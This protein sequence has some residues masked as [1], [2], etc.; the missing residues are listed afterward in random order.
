MKTN[1]NSQNRSSATG[2]TQAD[3]IKLGMDV[4]AET[5]VVVRILDKAT[6]SWFQ[7]RQLHSPNRE[8]RHQFGF[9]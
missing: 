4:H 3:T 1:I 7:H 2:I 9:F 5:L 8:Q 6:G